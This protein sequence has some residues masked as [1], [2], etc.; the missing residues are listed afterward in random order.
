M[1]ARWNGG[2]VPDIIE[3]LRVGLPETDGVHEFLTTSLV[4]H[5]DVLVKYQMGLRHTL[6]DDPTSYPEASATTGFGYYGITKA[7][8][9]GLIPREE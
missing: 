1:K 3:L 8:R 9:T 6:V 2:A 4:A 5:I 7:L